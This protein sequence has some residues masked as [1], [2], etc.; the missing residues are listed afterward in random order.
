MLQ[1]R[2]LFIFIFCLP[3]SAI[4]ADSPYNETWGKANRAYESGDYEEAAHL[5]QSLANNKPDVAYLYYNLGNAY[6]KLN[7]IGPAVLNYERA[8]CLEPGFREA[9]ENL[10]LTT[11]RIPNRILPA[12]EI[13]FIRWWKSITHPAL[14]TLWAISALV[15]F[16]LIVGIQWFR[17]RRKGIHQLRYRPFYTG[18]VVT[19]VLLLILAAASAQKMANP[20]K[21]VVMH[22]DTALQLEGTEKQTV[23]I[24]EGTVVTVLKTQ[25]SVCYVRL[26]DGRTGHLP[27]EALEA[28]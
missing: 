3:S 4:L 27:A 15:C 26:P 23:S 25:A 2:L 22:T 11:A 1:M 9:K 19:G 17:I 21:A 20:G 13:F 8:L 5:Y 12:E 14:A 10:A 7:R 16:L 24:P 28:I 6:Y 18:L